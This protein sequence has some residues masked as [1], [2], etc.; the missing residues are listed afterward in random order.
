MEKRRNCFLSY[1][2]KT[3]CKIFESINIWSIL[4]VNH[5]YDFF[6]TEKEKKN[7]ER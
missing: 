6:L 5:L 1:L 7:G 3:E 4:E 2:L